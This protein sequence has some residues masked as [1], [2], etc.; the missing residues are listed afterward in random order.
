[1]LPGEDKITDE[2]RP[3]IRQAIQDGVI[4]G[5]TGK[6]GF[7]EFGDTTTKVLTVYKVTNQEWAAVKTDEFK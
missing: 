1:V 2:L 7:D 3:K 4:D 5:V 6:V